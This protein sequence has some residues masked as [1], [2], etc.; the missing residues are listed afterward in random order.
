MKRWLLFG[1]M[2]WLV[3]AS[4]TVSAQEPDLPPVLDPSD[5]FTD[6]VEVV[7]TLPIFEYEN[8]ARLAYYF[9]PG[10]LAWAAY[11]YPDDLD[12][13]G[14]VVARPNGTY[15]VGPDVTG[16]I[17]WE[18]R[19]DV[20]W[21]FDPSAGGFVRPTMACG[22]VRDLPDEGEWR[23]IQNSDDERYYLCQTA[24]DER[25]GPLPEEISFGFTEPDSGQAWESPSGEWIVFQVG[26]LYDWQLFSYEVQTDNAYRLGTGIRPVGKA[27][28]EHWIDDS[29]MV[30]HTQFRY[31]GNSR[32]PT[33][34][35]ANVTESESLQV[36]Y[37][38]DRLFPEFVDNPPR[39][40]WVPAFGIP[41]DKR[42]PQADCRL[43]VFDLTTRELTVYSEMPNICGRGQII[44]DGTG[45][46]LYVFNYRVDEYLP[47]SVDRN[48]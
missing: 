18:L 38:D 20:K 47:I 16:G 3:M 35:I 28:V 44:N 42:D 7:E 48:G 22:R 43:H 13:I 33:I 26:S 40:E 6:A 23:V 19:H 14:G 34:Y 25:L 15:V 10:T 39:Y 17:Q 31:R 41:E 45:D 29:W 36:V 27:W 1:L 46:R 8:D 12:E 32:L 30:I 11:R 21:L 24:T 37:Q 9:D 4:W 5:V 2:G